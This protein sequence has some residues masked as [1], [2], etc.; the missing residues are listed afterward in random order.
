[1]NKKELIYFYIIAFMLSCLLYATVCF[2][3]LRLQTDNTFAF[4]LHAALTNGLIL[5]SIFFF[6]RI[7]E[8]YIDKQIDFFI[9]RFLLGSCVGILFFFTSFYINYYLVE[10]LPVHFISTANF[11]KTY[12]NL[13][14]NKIF[15][16]QTLIQYTVLY[17]WVFLFGIAELALSHYFTTSRSIQK[18]QKSFTQSQLTMIK[19]K[20]SP[21][22]LFNEL[23]N[24]YSLM[25][26]DHPETKNYLQRSLHLSESI[27]G[28]KYDVCSKLSE[29]IDGVRNYIE[30]QK[31]RFGQDLYIQ[32]NVASPLPNILLPSMS[33]LTLVEN[34]IK[35][36]DIEQKIHGFHIV[37][38]AFIYESDFV[39]RVQNR[40]KKRSNKKKG[41]GI[42]QLKKRLNE[43][44]GD[45]YF[46]KQESIG[47][48]FE[49]ELKIKFKI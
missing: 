44:Y 19:N 2:L 49:T 15:Y 32:D 26:L 10:L 42:A 14:G 39:F 29:E 3:N 21:H 35:H 13:I 37:I 36:F 30:L 8:R 31:I 23:N 6:L 41:L 27:I 38:D 20:M 43:F 22:F 18:I 1:M 9:L 34:A 48:I 4:V 5:S 17:F 47:N 24:I 28:E 12:F 11:E 16:E 25:V 46:L 33:L 40:F 45:T 7:Y